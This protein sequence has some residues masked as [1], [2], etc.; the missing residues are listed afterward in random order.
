[1]NFKIKKNKATWHSPRV[2]DALGHQINV[3][4]PANQVVHPFSQASSFPVMW[5]T[6]FVFFS[7]MYL[8][9]AYRQS[10][11]QP[12]SLSTAAQQCL[13]PR[14][15]GSR[16]CRPASSHHLAPPMQVTVDR[17]PVPLLSPFTPWRNGRH[18]IIGVKDADRSPSLY[19]VPTSSSS[20]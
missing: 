14:L 17:F 9:L 15:L 8:S 10:D 1:M 18:T 13:T 4:R 3:Q 19:D 20:L 7:L 16:M 12:P 11:T 6:Q 5:T 2:M